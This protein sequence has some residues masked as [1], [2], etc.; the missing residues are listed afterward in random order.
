MSS[1]VQFSISARKVIFIVLAVVL[2]AVGCGGPTP[3]PT[4]VDQV[5]I[6]PTQTATPTPIPKPTPTPVPPTP[7]PAPPTPTA[8]PRVHDGADSPESAVIT[9]LKAIESNDANA[10]LDVVDP[11]FRSNIGN[12]FFFSQLLSTL[13]QAFG[14]GG[15]LGKDAS[16]VNFRDLDARLIVAKGDLARV[17]ISG[18][19]RS[20]AF[21]VEQP[22]EDSV[23][24]RQIDGRWFISDVTEAEIASAAQEARQVEKQQAE[25]S[26][27][28]IL[29][30]GELVAVMSG[31][32]SG[33]GLRDPGAK[34]L[35][36]G[37]Q[38]LSVPALGLT[39]AGGRL[40]RV[41]L[42]P[43]RKRIA[44]SYS[45]CDPDRSIGVMEADGSNARDVLAR[46]LPG[47]V[48]GSFMPNWAPDS[49]RLVI[50][51]VTSGS[52]DAIMILDISS[53]DVETVWKGDAHDAI[54]MPDGNRIL[55]SY[56]FGGWGF[57][58]TGIL[59]VYD[60]RS[61]KE[62]RIANLPLAPENMVWS[63]D[64]RQIAFN[65]EKF[66]ADEEPNTQGIWLIN[67]DGSNLKRIVNK[68]SVRKPIWSPDGDFLIFHNLAESSLHW[69]GSIEVVH[70]DGTPIRGM[71]EFTEPTWTGVGWWIDGSTPAVDAQIG[72]VEQGARE[73][74]V[75]IGL[76][77]Q[78]FGL[79]IALQEFQVTDSNIRVHLVIL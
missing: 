68:P 27:D 74:T 16:Q 35:R 36:P 60:P 1:L 14:L 41:V 62:E 48:L 38:W 20:P 13:T 12:Y 26:A 39:G 64:M 47:C 25:L 79:N 65:F 28:A 22:L 78:V 44:W 24:V 45:N 19:V 21:A 29:Q 73:R 46:D 66:Y 31:T 23:L 71:I 8:V 30:Q 51:E 42:S 33:M 7:T 49:H 52:N 40:D 53:G 70:R 11:Q 55:M 34:V 17:W 4:P 72:F 75:D 10:Y 56:S 76:S 2:V 67:S 32:Y 69:P 61:G 15:S 3:S 5:T 50:S 58:G 77:D 18:F 9:A 54:F 43:D 6:Q 63:P 57:D 37:A 59:A